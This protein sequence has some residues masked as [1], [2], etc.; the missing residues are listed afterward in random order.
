MFV[1]ARTLPE[2]ETLE[3]D[4]AIIGAGAAGIAIAREFA[5]RQINGAPIRVLL[6]ES[7][8]L[9]FDAETQG[10]YDGESVGIPYPLDTSRL[11]YFGGSTNH[12]GGW[13]RPLDAIDFQKRDWVPHSGWPV[14]RAELDPFYDRAAALCQIPT[15]RFDD[16][17]TWHEDGKNE[18]LPLPGGDVLT[19]YFL[20]SPPT[21]FGV[22]YR[23]EIKNAAN[24]TT[25][26]HANVTGIVAN[27][28]ASAVSSLK[29]AT[30]SGRH[31]IVKP[32]TTILATG[33][34]E[35]A[36]LLLASNSVMKA[37]LGNGHD[38]VGRYFMEHPHVPG[39]IAFIGLRDTNLIPPYYRGYTPIGDTTMRAIFMFSADYQRRQKTL[40]TNMAIYPLF[41][42]G[43]DI[44][45]QPW[46]DIEPSIIDLLPQEKNEDARIFGVSCATEQA[47]DP[48]SRITLGETRDALGMRQ[49]VIDWRLSAFDHNA[50]SMNIDALAR[51]IGMWGEGRVRV[52]FARRDT[53]ESE[54]QGWGN[55][56]M[57]TTR[58]STNPR[59]GVVD[60]NCKVHGLA[61]LYVAGSSVFPTG[62]AV[63][64]TLTL[65][66]MALR[67]SDHLANR[68]AT[69]S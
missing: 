2:G 16:H 29:I 59:N 51:A 32:G 58:I 62:G 53:W 5:D 42:P 30:L 55:H 22:T 66:A 14:T 47:P 12:W 50:L 67:L 9:E 15:P 44:E 27:P 35:N 54:D 61:N 19:R 65:L 39:Q 56:H 52:G 64:P 8:G 1:D 34:I 25:L 13:C 11:R 21:R 33:G 6:I 69:E 10:L 28:E 43:M 38:N 45:G 37:G 36:R 46:R 31:I 18:I 4:L 26:L 3:T 23:Q 48:A 49:S 17:A 63:N 20:Y 68:Y 60:E 57:G 40:G 7:G 24:I 41:L